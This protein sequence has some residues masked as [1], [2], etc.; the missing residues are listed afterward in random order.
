[1]MGR[2]HLV[3]GVCALEHLWAISVL[4]ENTKNRFLIQGLDVVMERFEIK[5][6]LSLPWNI[7]LPMFP[8]FL[9]VY[10]VGIL[11]PDVDNP[12]SILGR[13]IHIPVEHRTWI[14]A[15]Y[16]YI[17]TGIAGIFI[18][19]A[20]LWFTLGVFV[21]LFWDNFSK[22]GNCW[23]YKLLSDYREYP[24]GAKIKKGNH[25]VLYKAGEWTEYLVTFIVV[26]LTIMSFIYIRTNHKSAVL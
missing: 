12:N 4:V 5:L 15:V 26:M 7:Y 25:L 14:H 3:T 13:I 24:N 8:I 22:M 21:H 23:F 6:Q 9:A 18:H 11:F 17:A 1:M 2:N 19:P 10:F 16:L 20:F